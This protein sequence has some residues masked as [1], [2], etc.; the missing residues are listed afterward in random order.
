MRWVRGWGG[1]FRG[2]LSADDWLIINGVG[3]G[4]CGGR[5]FLMVSE[6]RLRGVLQY[7]SYESL[8]EQLGLIISTVKEH[9]RGR[10]GPLE[11]VRPL[12]VMFQRHLEAEV[13]RG[14]V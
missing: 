9:S 1:S 12:K 14:Q 11:K 5:W 6:L 10:P 7:L 4:V 13:R 3:C 8:K 2:R